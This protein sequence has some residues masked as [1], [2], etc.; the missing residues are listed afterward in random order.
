M[1]YIKYIQSADGTNLY[2]KVNEVS[3]PKA[4]I[5]VVH[6]LAEHLERYDHIT[7]FLNDNQFNVIRYDQRGHGRSDGK[8]VYYSNKGEIVEDLDAMIQ[9]VKETYKGNVYLIGHSMGGYTVTLYGTKH[10][11]LVDGMITSGALTRYNLKLFGEP[12]RSQP[13]DKYLPNELGDGVCSDEDT[14]RKYELDDLVAKDISFGLIYTLL[15]GVELL[16]AQAAS[17]TD[18]ILILHGKEDGLV[19][20]QDSLELFNDISSE[21]KSIHIYDGL[22][23]EIFNEASYNQSIFQEIVDWLNHNVSQ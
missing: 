19:S 5:I 8:P 3:E 6:G 10:P 1:N 4:N 20:Y 22:K 13:E 11:G 21:H 16:K 18:P 14:I 12:D 15:D 9:F 17:F 7:T 2:A 23:H